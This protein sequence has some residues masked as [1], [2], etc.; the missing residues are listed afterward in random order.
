MKIQLLKFGKPRIRLQH[1]AK[2]DK[3]QFSFSLFSLF[4][5]IAWYFLIPKYKKE[6]CLKNLKIGICFSFFSD[7]IKINL[8]GSNQ[9]KRLLGLE[10]INVIQ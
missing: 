4:Y 8:Y 1:M 7:E 5:L 2:D 3:T 9:D 10:K 6:N